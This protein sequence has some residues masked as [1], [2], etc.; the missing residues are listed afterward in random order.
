MNLKKYWIPTIKLGTL[1]TAATTALTGACHKYREKTIY[2]PGR[3][4]ML[5]IFKSGHHAPFALPRHGTK[6]GKQQENR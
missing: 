4:P 3:L 2:N 5:L 1:L 6:T